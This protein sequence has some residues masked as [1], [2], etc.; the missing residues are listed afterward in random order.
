LQPPPE[1]KDLLALRPMPEV[2]AALRERA[3][4]IT[5]RWTEAVDRYLPDADPL[6][7]KQVRNSIPTVLEKI[8]LALE[9]GSPEQTEV[10]EEVGVAHGVARFQQHYDIEEVVIEYRLLRRVIFDELND[11]VGPGKL[12][13]VDAI[14]V[15]MGVDTA[16]H[17][18]VTSF[19]RHLTEELR[20]AAATES[21][22]LSFLSHDLR[23]NLNGVTLML[24]TL[25]HALGDAPQFAEAVEDIRALRRT[26]FE[27]VTGMDRLLQ[28]ERLR[29]QAVTLKLGPVDLRRLAAEVTAQAAV[30]AREKGLAIETAVPAGA[31]AHSDRELLLLILQN[32]IGNAVKFSARGAVR[33]EARNDP[34]GWRVAVIDQGPGIAPDRVASLFDAFSRGETHGQPGMGLGLTIASHAARLLGSELQVESKPGGGST[35]SFTVPPAKPDAAH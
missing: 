3:E 7:T 32:L 35:F 18:G 22:Y 11:A 24:E 4:R 17:R 2:A 29:K 1:T 25:T 16:L 13:F 31:A 5:T 10:L 15:D 34:L 20:S 19:V 28:A 6:T 8:A 27:T 9:S 23:N 26:V 33:V 21:K 12:T 30:A 14:A